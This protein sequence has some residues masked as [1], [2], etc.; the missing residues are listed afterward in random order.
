[1]KLKCPIIII[2][3]FVIFVCLMTSSTKEGA[4][5]KLI[6]IGDDINIYS[7]GFDLGFTSSNIQ[8]CF[9]ECLRRSDCNG[10]L[11]SGD[12]D[13]IQLSYRNKCFLKSRH[14]YIFRNNPYIP[15]INTSILNQWNSYV[16]VPDG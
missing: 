15:S 1:M 13:T 4:E 10:V 16:K 12:G 3:A 2:L 8:E 5:M 11:V 6:N 9:D 7:Y 14:G